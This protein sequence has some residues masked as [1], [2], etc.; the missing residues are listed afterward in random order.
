MQNNRETA[1]FSSLPLWFAI[2]AGRHLSGL[3]FAKDHK[4]DAAVGNQTV[5]LICHLNGEAGCPPSQVKELGAGD[6]LVAHGGRPEVLDVQVGSGYQ[7]ARR[8][9]RFWKKADRVHQCGNQAAVRTAEVVSMLFA[10]RYRHDSVLFANLVKMNTQ[11]AEKGYGIA[12]FQR[13]RCEKF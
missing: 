9:K 5:V 6:E 11:G 1:K 7:T 3:W 12:G 10:Y 8:K 13:G 2:R 4:S